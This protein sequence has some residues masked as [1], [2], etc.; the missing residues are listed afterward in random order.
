MC[1]KGKK[2]A[3]NYLKSILLLLLDKSRFSGNVWVIKFFSWRGWKRPSAAAAT[4]TCGY[5]HTTSGCKKF[6]STID[7]EFRESRIY[8]IKHWRSC[9]CK[10]IMPLKKLQGMVQ[11]IQTKPVSVNYLRRV[12]P[13]FQ[14]N[15]LGIENRNRAYA[16]RW[17]LEIRCRSRWPART[18]ER[19]WQ[20]TSHRYHSTF[21]KQNIISHL[22]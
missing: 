20:L 3:E 19:R 16:P 11:A 14:A 1:T 13:P 2:Q 15:S 18:T 17:H 5:K 22:V 6:C 8:Q 12:S 9:L 7:V 10:E 21:H 4:A